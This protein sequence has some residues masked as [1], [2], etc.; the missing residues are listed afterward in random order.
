MT[1]PRVALVALAAA[2]IGAA[3]AAWLF[4]GHGD[5]KVGVALPLPPSKAVAGQKTAPVAMK[6]VEAYPH[7]VKRKAK[8]PAAV[9]EDD[10]QHLIAAGKLETEER[11]YNIY[12][13][14]DET[15]G[16]SHVYSQAEPL[17]WLA[18]GR[19]GAVGIAYGLSN[20]ELEGK[21]YAYQDLLKV[22]ALAAGV[23]AEIDSS[24][25]HFVGGY[26]EYRF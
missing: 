23:R 19:R 25:N 22:K 6:S 2:M 4:Y 20:G 13:L 24:A 3:L 8:L 18:L 14:V 7:K 12:A 15:T 11:P 16:E 5:T 21:L 17:P 26:V 1:P 10:K 9:V